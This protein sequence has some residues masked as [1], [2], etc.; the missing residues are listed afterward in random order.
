M[1]RRVVFVQGT[2][3][4]LNKLEKMFNKWF[5]MVYRALLLKKKWNMHE[6]ITGRIVDGLE[7]ET[8]N[9]ATELAFNNYCALDGKRKVARPLLMVVKEKEL[10]REGL[11][12]FPCAVRERK[13]MERRF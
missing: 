8:G 9:R 4:H 6:T 1:E 2:Q 7:V 12:C 11:K 10:E 5:N 3:S 13:E